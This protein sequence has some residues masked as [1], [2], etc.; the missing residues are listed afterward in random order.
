M[1]LKPGLPRLKKRH[2]SQMIELAIK[3]LDVPLFRNLAQF[4]KGDDQR[5]RLN[6]PAAARELGRSLAGVFH[7]SGLEFS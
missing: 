7:D 6:Q 4:F 1:N 2:R 5:S 3:A